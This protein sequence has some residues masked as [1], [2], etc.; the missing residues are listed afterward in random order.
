MFPLARLF[1][2]SKL[3]VTTMN[4]AIIVSSM[5]VSLF[6]TLWEYVDLRD[7]EKFISRYTLV[8]RRI[9]RYSPSLCPV[10]IIIDV[11]THQ[12]L[13]QANLHHILY[14]MDDCNVLCIIILW[15]YYCFS[16]SMFVTKVIP[17]IVKNA[18][19]VLMIYKFT[20]CRTHK[21]RGI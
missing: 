13:D 14:H 6:F 15:A 12:L 21:S 9:T 19:L 8:R 17:I 11:Q 7:A 18:F 20:V 3:L 4:F 5:H 10:M 2:E 16:F 1:F